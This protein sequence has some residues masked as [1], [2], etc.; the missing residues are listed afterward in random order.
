MLTRRK[1][2]FKGG[3]VPFEGFDDGLLMVHFEMQ[4]SFHKHGKKVQKYGSKVWWMLLL[5]KLITR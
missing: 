1:C 4:T 3:N 5:L 2:Y